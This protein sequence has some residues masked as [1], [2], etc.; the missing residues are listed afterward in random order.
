MVKLIY[1]DLFSGA[2]GVT[3][4]V[5]DA[6][7]NGEKAAKVIAA[8]NHDPIAIASHAANHPETKHF[9]EDIKMRMLRIKELKLIT[10]FSEA[11]TLLGTQNDQKKFIGNAVPCL[12]PQRMTEALAERLTN[13]RV[14]I[15]V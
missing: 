10:G 9:T 7:I 12:I 15:A 6:R 4:G 5:E 8:V 11:Y 13:Y 3:T 2:G 1:I 14:S